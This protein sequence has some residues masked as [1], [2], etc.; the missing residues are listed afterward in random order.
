MQQERRAVVPV[1]VS[2]GLLSK[3]MT[4]TGEL[5]RHS[6]SG[7]RNGAGLD[8]LPWRGGCLHICASR[9]KRNSGFESGSASRNDGDDCARAR[10]ER[11][12]SSP[13]GGS[14][15]GKEQGSNN[16]SWQAGACG[17]IGKVR[18]TGC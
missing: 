18:D 2:G 11:V 16:G 13:S 17:I 9:G 12:S 10:C 1:S 8:D 5:A 4:E 6:G 3:L 7:F 14:R 15:E